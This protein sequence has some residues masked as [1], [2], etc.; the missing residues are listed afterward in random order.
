MKIVSARAGRQLRQRW[1]SLSTWV[2]A[3]S[4][5]ERVALFCTGA[6]LLVVVSN[7]LFLDAASTRAAAQGRQMAIDITAASAPIVSRRAQ[8]NLAIRSMPRRKD[9]GSAGEPR[10][11]TE[12]VAPRQGR[13]RTIV[14]CDGAVP[15]NVGITQ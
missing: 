11:S 6:A 7:K 2:D 8:V 4:L 13:P 12:V 9:C 15:R 5:G 10:C 14:H 1:I 3:R